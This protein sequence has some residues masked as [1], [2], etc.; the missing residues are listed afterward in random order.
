MNLD[1]KPTTLVMFSGGMD[2]TYMLWRLL[3]D[4]AVGPIHLHHMNI[5]NIENR[6]KAEALAVA[7]IRNYFRV[8]GLEPSYSESTHEMPDFNGSFP[9]DTHFVYTVAATL[10]LSFPQFYRVLIGRTAHDASRAIN[11]A[12]PNA[13]KVFH[14]F[15]PKA[16]LEFP[17]MY[18]AQDEIVAGLPE[19]LLALTWTCRTPWYDGQRPM[20]CGKCVNCRP[21]SGRSRPRPLGASGATS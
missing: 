6:A 11:R 17:L 18:T 7:Q 19:D 2:S 14:I 15:E 16:A 20:P 12:G 4:P 5:I 10:C 3:Q 13:D 1:P 9:W 8:R 21:G